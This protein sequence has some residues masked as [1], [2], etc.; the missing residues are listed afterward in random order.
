MTEGNRGLKL[1]ETLSI[2]SS[3]TITVSVN[4]YP[5]ASIRAD[6]KELEVELK[7]VKEA[8]LSPSKFVHLERGRKNILSAS[9]SMA[10]E[11]S[12]TGWKLTVYDGGD[13]LVAMGRGVSRLT[14][15]IRLNPLKVKK[16][17]DALN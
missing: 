16:L 11:L 13:R 10:K 17:L 15:R 1:L 2:L 12:D 3:G 5:L 7:G 9:E 8:G 4:G 6:E 14:G